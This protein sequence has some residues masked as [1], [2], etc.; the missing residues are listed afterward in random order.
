MADSKAAIEREIESKRRKLEELKRLRAARMQSQQLSTEETNALLAPPTT[1]HAPKQSADEILKSVSSLIATPATATATTGSP[2]A[3]PAAASASAASSPA[4]ASGSP[5]PSPKLAPSAPAHIDI[6]A[7]ESKILYEQSTQTDL[8]RKQAEAEAAAAVSGTAAGTGTN[9]AAV[10]DSI[11]ENERDEIILE[12]DELRAR[13]VTL[14]SRIRE[15]AQQNEARQ[16][17]AEQAAEQALHAELA[18]AEAEK[19]LASEE[20]HTFLDRSSK[21]VER[22]LG[23]E[24]RNARGSANGAAGMMSALGG[25]FDYMSD[26]S[27]ADEAGAEKN[28]AQGERHRLTPSVVFANDTGSASSRTTGRAVTSVNWSPKFP[29]LL[30]ASYAPEH[31]GISLGDDGLSGGSSLSSGT[32]GD[33]ALRTDPDG[34]VLVWNLNMSRRAEFVFQCQSAVHKAMFHPAHPKLVVGA[35]ENGQLVIWDMRTA[36]HTPVNRSS[37]SHG[38]THPVFALD[39]QPLASGVYQLVSASSDGQVCVW[40][41]NNLH[42]PLHDVQLVNLR[43]GAAASLA[44]VNMDASGVA[45]ATVAAAREDITTT[46]F[47]LPARDTNTLLLG[48]DEGRIYK[49]RLHDSAGSVGGGVGGASGGSSGGAQIYDVIYAHDAPMSSLQFHPH[50]KSAGSGASAAANAPINDLFLTSSLDW[51]VKLWSQ[52]LNKPL[53]VFETA[54]DYVHAASWCPANPYVFASGDGTGRLDLW[55]LG[56]DSA[57]SDDVDVPAVSVQ[58]GGSSSLGSAGDMGADASAPASTVSGAPSA[59][60]DAS[61][62]SSALASLSK[63]NHAISALKWNHTGSMIACGLSSGALHL[64]DVSSDLY[65]P[66]H[67]ATERFYDKIAY[68]LAMP[69]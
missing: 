29:E 57:V 53:F 51:T 28:G 26:Y 27:A 52:R 44:G 46:C 5:R 67:E 13:E 56:G 47:D 34:L 6:P 54:R 36:K 35:C 10:W 65:S 2:A 20:F 50:F 38:H 48:S 39:I 4:N 3:S 37:L 1:H 11:D 64:Y 49:A 16:V 25:G 18:P 33:N 9:T 15:L 31:A 62:P 41:E 7:G 14:L 68:R 42:K 69:R 30:L 63:P 17:A 58:V 66:S 60:I 45:A 59:S 40:T 43:Q 12:R 23:Y 19:I 22:L 24:S 32:G 8:K 55:H 21:I 61:D